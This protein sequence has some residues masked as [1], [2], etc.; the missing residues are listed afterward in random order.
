MSEL[1]NEQKIQIIQ[2][3]IQT[4]VYNGFNL[5]V[6]ILEEK[7]KNTPDQT[8][9]TNLYAQSSDCERQINALNTELAKLQVPSA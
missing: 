3:H 4:V 1:S 5:E 2:T 8:V 7:A 9:L 6:S